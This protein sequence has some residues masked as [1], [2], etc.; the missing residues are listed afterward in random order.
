MKLTNV[1]VGGQ[2][3]TV[4]NL[5]A[6]AR[7][8][9]NVRYDPTNFSGLIWQH[10]KIGGNCLVFTNGYINCN[11]PCES[12]EE[13]IKRLRRYARLLQKL[14]YCYTLTGIKIITASA[15]HRLDGKVTLEHIPFKYRYEPEL[16]PAIMFKRNN[17]HFTL[18]FSGVLI[19]TGI[20]KSK[21][22]DDV[23]YPVILEL[24]VSL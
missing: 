12:F 3:D 5:C 14:G 19:I 17:I 2:L 6:L 10:R 7:Q 1:V 23:I 20:K 15:S 4:M 21:D 22:L 13:G 11:G 9:T 16:F 18:H 24:A 8:L